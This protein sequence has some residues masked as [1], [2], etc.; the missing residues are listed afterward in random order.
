MLHQSPSSNTS[1]PAEISISNKYL[2]AIPRFLQQ[3]YPDLELGQIVHQRKPTPLIPQPEISTGS[4][5]FQPGLPVTIK[6]SPARSTLKIPSKVPPKFSPAGS[7]NKIFGGTFLDLYHLQQCLD[8]RRGQIVHRR[9]QSHHPSS[10]PSRVSA[11]FII[12]QNICIFLK[13]DMF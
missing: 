1:S 11:H 2:S 12:K 8:S 7:M 9:N 10:S 6:R 5:F 13:M 3:W 4:R